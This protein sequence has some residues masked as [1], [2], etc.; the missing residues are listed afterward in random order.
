MSVKL[1]LNEQLVSTMLRLE[2]LR[3]LNGFSQTAKPT[4]K[5]GTYEEVLL[6]YAQKLSKSQLQNGLKR[7]A[8]DVA[9][10]A[11]MPQIRLLLP[12][13]ATSA[14]PAADI[15][16]MTQLPAMP[17]PAALNM[18]VAPGTPP[19]W[20][21]GNIS[22]HLKEVYCLDETN[23]FWGSE[24]GEDEIY[25]QGFGVNHKAVTQKW[26][27][28]KA[29]G[30]SEEINSFKVGNFEESSA[31]R[32]VKTYAP[33]LTLL[34]FPMANAFPLT[35]TNTLI[36]VES[37][38][39]G[40]IAKEAR[41][42]IEKANEYIKKFV[43]GLIGQLPIS[44]E[45]INQIGN[46]IKKAAADVLNWFYESFFGNDLFKPLI[47]QFTIPASGVLDTVVAEIQAAGDKFTKKQITAAQAIALVKA[48]TDKLPRGLETK[49][50]AGHGGKYRL[51][52]E[53]TVYPGVGL[54]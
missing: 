41:K 44:G 51:T 13:I 14:K 40:A 11:A 45:W 4:A 31:T 49:E 18:L 24:E 52:W 25:L 10:D 30:S 22:F 6:G 8:A 43:D 16:A 38:D 39:G 46:W 19:L 28:R 26:K 9:V 27:R 3:I 48:A 2:T 37:D 20:M 29:N 34:E 21:G 36:L 35:V 17:K 5:A 50:I 15:A 47:T 53:W 33:A 23:G 54:G 42:L 1:T 32:R 12:A 7:M